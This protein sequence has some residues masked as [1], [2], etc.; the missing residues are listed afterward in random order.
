MISRHYLALKRVP[1]EVAAL[2]REEARTRRLRLT[3]ERAHNEPFVAHVGEEAA[4]EIYDRVRLYVTPASECA[5]RPL[6]EQDWR[7]YGAPRWTR[8]LR[9]DVLL[10]WLRQWP[11]APLT[12]IRKRLRV[13]DDG[14]RLYFQAK[15]TTYAEFRAA[16]GLPGAQQISAQNRGKP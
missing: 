4:E 2:R 10:Y 3:L 12:E 1:P 16:N 7:Q 5:T 8:T 9:P 13:T 14:V 15:G 6:D 11:W